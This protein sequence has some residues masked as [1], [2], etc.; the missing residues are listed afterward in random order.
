MMDDRPAYSSEFAP[1]ALA[2]VQRLPHLDDITAEWA[3][4]GS[5]GRG[6]KVAVIDSGVDAEHPDVGRVDGYVAV[7]EGDGGMV[8]DTTPHADV[9]GH[10]TACAGIIRALAPDCEI[11]SVRVL[12]AALSGRA[13][14][15]AAGLRWAIENGMHVCNLSLGTTKKDYFGLFHE[16]ADLAYFRRVLLV[17]AANNMPIPS[18]PSVYASVIAVAAHGMRDSQLIYYNPNPPVEF[19]APGIDVRVAWLEKGYVTTT[20]NSFAAPHITGLVARIIAKHP[21]L[22]P[23]HVKAVLRALAANVTRE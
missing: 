9:Y 18:F 16:L 5:T 14:V 7:N 1:E 3:W 20:G 2:T 11:Y 15:F 22:A 19:G 17:T 23:F 13:L 21:D 6:V 10:G 8:Y 12:G 4:G